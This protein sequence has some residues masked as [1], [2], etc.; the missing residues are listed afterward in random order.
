MVLNC[1]K[2]NMDIVSWW[3]RFVEGDYWNLLDIEKKWVKE[4]KWNEVVR[5]MNL[6]V[7]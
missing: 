7:K 2:E 6:M 5:E 3:W 4:I 1:V